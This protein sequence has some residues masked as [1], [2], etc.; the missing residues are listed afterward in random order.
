MATRVFET[1]TFELQDGTE[2][3]IRPLNIKRLRKFM[4]VVDKFNDAGDDQTEIVD[5]M[6]DACAIAVEATNEELAADRDKLEDI[7]DVPT[8]YRIL[9]I[10]GGIKLDDPNLQRAAGVGPT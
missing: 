9:E 6:V 8:M 2:V 3:L 5:L 10:A 1:E 7:L 4:E